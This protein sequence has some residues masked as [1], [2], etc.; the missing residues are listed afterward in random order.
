MNENT[1]NNIYEVGPANN[2][3]PESL[4]IFLHG[5]GSNGQDLISLAPMFSKQLP[6][7]V[8]VSPDAPFPCDMVPPGYPNSYQWFSLQDRDPD[9]VL[10]G[11]EH[12]AP[13]VDDFIV[14]EAEKYGVPFNK[15]AL[16]GFSQGTMLSL[17][18][19]TRF[20]EK[21]AGV[22]GYSGAMVGLPGESKVPVH[23][24][25]GE[26]DDVVPVSAYH[27]ARQLLEK[28]GFNVSGHTSPD[29]Q[30]SINEIGIKSG[31]GFLRSVFS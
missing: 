30:H 8:F 11:V 31:A 6:S 10:A 19:A 24:V 3:K 29:L 20:K 5:L 26:A 16:V 2:Q 27:D 22:L 15:I 18:V 13:I 14:Q 4:V 28:C 23:I 25:H 7:T 12:V 21:L 17:Y 9:K 1:V